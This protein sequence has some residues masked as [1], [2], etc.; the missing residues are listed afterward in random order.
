MNNPFKYTM[1]LSLI[2]IYIS[3]VFVVVF[4]LPIIITCFFLLV[5][6]CSWIAL[7]FLN[8]AKVINKDKENTQKIAQNYLVILLSILS[9]SYVVIFMKGKLLIFFLIGPCLFLINSIFTIINIKRK[10][11]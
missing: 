1:I 4:S 11:K 7:I 6:F 3:L 8:H 9:I 5:F 10:S 2:L